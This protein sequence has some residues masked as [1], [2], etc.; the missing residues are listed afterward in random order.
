[1]RKQP[2]DSWYGHCQAPVHTST[3]PQLTK[4][5]VVL[6]SFTIVNRVANILLFRKIIF[7][8]VDSHEYLVETGTE[9][10]RNLLDD[11]AVLEFDRKCSTT[12][13]SA[14]HF[15]TGCIH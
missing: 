6:I 13:P 7:D 3:R 11:A 15:Q 4:L 8:T 14:R 10:K 2:F 1:M 5:L 9:R 12:N